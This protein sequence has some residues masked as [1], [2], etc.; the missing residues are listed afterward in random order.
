[1]PTVEFDG[2]GMNYNR[3]CEPG[4]FVQQHSVT[5]TKGLLDE[6]AK[7]PQAHLKIL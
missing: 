6:W 4:P 5:F 2:G 3:V 1:M 7:F